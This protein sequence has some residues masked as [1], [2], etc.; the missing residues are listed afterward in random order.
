MEYQSLVY[1]F[2]S[3]SSFDNYVRIDKALHLSVEDTAKK[4]NP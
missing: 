3:H 1:R 4:D 2:E